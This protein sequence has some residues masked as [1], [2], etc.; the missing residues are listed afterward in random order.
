M[1]EPIQF[2]VVLVRR[3]KD[4]AFLSLGSKVEHATEA[5]AVAEIER[6]GTVAWR[7]NLAPLGDEQGCFVCGCSL[8]KP[9]E[10]RERHPERLCGVCELEATDADGRSVAFGNVDMFGG[11]VSRYR[12]TGES[13]GR[14]E[15]FV[16]GRACVANEARFGGIVIVPAKS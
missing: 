14:H 8:G 11:F 12:D 7:P 5:A 16:R 2:F 6:S 10:A 13:Y 9:L 15:C 4:G 1:P 3:E